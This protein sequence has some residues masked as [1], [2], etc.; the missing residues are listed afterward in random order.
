MNNYK[1]WLLLLL[2]PQILPWTLYFYVT[3][4]RC[5]TFADCRLQTTDYRLQ[6]AYSGPQTIDYK[7]RWLTTDRKSW[8]P[9]SLI[10]H[11]SLSH[12]RYSPVIKTENRNHSMKKVKSLRYDKWLIYK[13]PRQESGLCCF[14]FARYLQK[15]V[16]KIYRALYGDA[17]G[18]QTWQ[19]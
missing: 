14:S 13:Q 1:T 19:P 2:L 9:Q 18:T 6:T 11:K 15:C 12:S 7:R 5:L 10:R 4:K 16:T 8:R 3:L 17:W